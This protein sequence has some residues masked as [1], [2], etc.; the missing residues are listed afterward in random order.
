M[1]LLR[2]CPVSFY[3]S[4]HRIPVFVV[5]FFLLLLCFLFAVYV[6]SEHAEYPGLLH[7][8]DCSESYLDVIVALGNCIDGDRSLFTV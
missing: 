1:L 4:L 5:F 2:D 3:S 8:L 6:W 7:G